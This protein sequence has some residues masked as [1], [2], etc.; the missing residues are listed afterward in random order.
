M[1]LLCNNLKKRCDESEAGERQAEGL[2]EKLIA[3]LDR[4]KT[5]YESLRELY[6]DPNVSFA[7]YVAD[8]KLG[9]RDS[10]D[11]FYN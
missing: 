11:E 10:I 8:N 4:M 1:E 5:R 3:E 2:C 9:F 7:E 6:G